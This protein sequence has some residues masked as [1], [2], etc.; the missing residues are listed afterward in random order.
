[1]ERIQLR[2]ELLTKQR[3]IERIDAQMQQLAEE[4]SALVSEVSECNGGA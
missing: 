3:R 2:S 4:R 1:M